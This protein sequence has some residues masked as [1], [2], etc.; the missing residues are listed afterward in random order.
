MKTITMRQAA[1][2]LG[3]NLGSII[4]MRAKGG[5]L[6]DPT[7]PAMT[8]DGTFREADILAWRAAKRVSNNPPSVTPA[9]AGGGIFK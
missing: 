9:V 4:L 1:Q 8:P 2:L 7:F 6:F 5:K 3:C